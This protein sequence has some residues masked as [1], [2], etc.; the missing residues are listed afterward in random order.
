MTLKAVNPA[1]LLMAPEL[2]PE[3]V[4][5][6]RRVGLTIFNTNMDGTIV[7]QVAIWSPKFPPAWSGKIL[8]MTTAK[9]GDAN[10]P[11]LC[12]CFF[13]AGECPDFEPFQRLEEKTNA[14]EQRKQQDIEGNP[15]ADAEP[16]SG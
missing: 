8:S 14:E 12:V 10:D 2:H 4:H 5:I 9:H 7:W 15:D 16:S 13:D 11:D 6:A 1:I 3:F